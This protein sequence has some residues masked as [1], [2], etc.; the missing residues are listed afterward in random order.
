[1]HRFSAKESFG[2]TDRLIVTLVLLFDWQPFRLVLQRRK[3]V[4][5]QACWCYHRVFFHATM[6]VAWNDWGETECWWPHSNFIKSKWEQQLGAWGLGQRQKLT[7]HIESGRQRTACYLFLA[8]S[9]HQQKLSVCMCQAW[10]DRPPG[11]WTPWITVL[12]DRLRRTKHFSQSH[13]QLGHT[14][15]LYRRKRVSWIG[16]SLC[17]HGRHASIQD[18]QDRELDARGHWGWIRSHKTIHHRLSFLPLDQRQWIRRGS[19]QSVWIGQWK[20]VLASPRQLALPRLRDLYRLQHSG[21]RQR[22]SWFDEKFERSPWP[23]CTPGPRN[24]SEQVYRCRYLG[25]LIRNP[26]VYQAVKRLQRV[27]T[28]LPRRQVELFN[29]SA[30][31]SSEGD[32]GWGLWSLH[33]EQRDS[34]L[35]YERQ[36]GTPPVQC[37][38]HDSL[39]R[40]RALHEE[41]RRWTPATGSRSDTGDAVTVRAWTLQ[42]ASRIGPH[43]RPIVKPLYLHWER[44]FESGDWQ[45]DWRGFYEALQVDLAGDQQL[46]LQG[47]HWDWAGTQWEES[48][49]ASYQ[50]GD[51]PSWGHRSGLQ[52]SPVKANYHGSQYPGWQTA[53]ADG[54]H[55]DLGY[56]RD[57]ASN[58]DPNHPQKDNS[59]ST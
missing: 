56:R 48:Y 6:W 55:R 18:G 54:I 33:R 13:L 45:A 22:N 53:G 39:R 14:W 20:R 59:T 2:G 32:S 41:N 50:G 44:L 24:R 7:L 36:T 37:H 46:C 5:G 35:S 34:R 30:F 28:Y 40:E 42:Q 1:M 52:G 29:K 43:A 16:R 12:R 26:C 11:W 21:V 3:L 51:G 8:S 19:R 10:P 57:R 23:S 17:E 49:S 9:P 47:C 58:L 25:W 38:K 4:W 15:G 27:R 31:Y